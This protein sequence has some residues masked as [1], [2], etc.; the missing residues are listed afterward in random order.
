MALGCVGIALFGIALGELIQ[1]QSADAGG[2]LG[3]IG[4]ILAFAILF[5]IR[6]VFWSRISSMM[7]NIVRAFV[8]IV[9]ILSV[10]ANFGL[11]GLTLFGSIQ[12]NESTG[13]VVFTIIGAITQIATVIWLIKYRRE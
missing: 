11:L 3:T 5:A 4:E 12:G 1:P 9:M 7:Q 13:A 8:T 10:F 6:L 2:T